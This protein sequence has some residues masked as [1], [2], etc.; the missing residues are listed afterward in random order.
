M[1]LISPTS[2][3]LLD[4]VWISLDLET[5]GLSAD[6]DEI[7]EIGAVKFQSE[8]ALDT[9][10][11]YVN[12]NRRLSSF[13]R[14]YTGITQA[15]VDGS[16]TFPMVMG[17]LASFV[18]SS[19]VVGHNIPFDL[20]F[21]DKK[22][23]RL[24][25]ERS[26]TWD[27]A[28]MLY[29]TLSDYSLV[30]LANW[31]KI[32]HP[33]PHRAIEDAIVTKDVFLKLVEKLAQVD[34][35]TLA[36]MRRLASRSSWVLSYILSRA[37]STD[38]GQA[39][40]SPG[41][42]GVGVGATGLDIDA[43]RTRLRHERAL[44]PNQTASELDVDF[45]GSLLQGGGPLSE[46]LPG[47]EEREEQVAMARAVAE[48]INNG[49]RLIVEAGT[50]VGKSMAYLLPALLYAS[51][52]NKRVVVSTNTINLQEQL[53]TKDIPTLLSGLAG[54]DGVSVEDVAFTQLKGR[55]NYLCLRRWQHLRSSENLSANDARVLAK[56]LV[57]LK[58]TTAG[59]RSEL[60]LG[61]RSTAAPWER[62]SAQGA[63]D[64]QGM[65]GLCFL[66][67]ARDKAAAAHIVV[68]NHAL[69]LSDLAAGGSLIPQ[70]DILIIDEAHHLEEEATRRLGF[71]LA[72][73]LFDEHFQS[74]S[75]ERGLLNQAVDA[76]RGSSTASTRRE[77][78][79]QVSAEATALLPRVRDHVARLY[80][81]L[82][83]ISASDN[84]E[85]Q[86]AFEEFR[87]TSGT[88][89]QPAWSELEIQ[90][91][92]VDVAMAELGNSLRGLQ[93]SLEALEEAGLVDYDGLMLEL[94]NAQQ[95]NTDLRQKLAEFVP[96]PKP[97]GI[98]WVARGGR[99]ADLT[100]HSAPMHVGETLDSLLFSKKQCVV[101]T[102]ATLSINESFD[103]IRQRT[104]FEG[105]EELL[106]G[107]PFDY[108][109]AALLCVPQDM[110][111]PTARDYQSA[112]AEA[113]SGASLAVGG[114]TMALFTS[115]ASLR[116]TASAIRGNLAARG[117]A[118]LAQGVDGSP[119]QLMRRFLRDPKSV[120]LG[121][122]S[123][124][125]GSTS[126]AS[127]SSC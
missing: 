90:W 43:L 53:L 2:S 108:P 25:G 104:G 119:H 60:N 23:L 4:E 28:F 91:E 48:A 62:L 32:P 121:T 10:Q 88:R 27:M 110:P 99:D 8:S 115:H 109:N 103:H 67:A 19:P 63:L 51:E 83:A 101:M 97:E 78:V 26:D 41:A 5:T 61:N 55:A 125:E 123:F 126:R 17:E 47:F 68:V 107:S 77:S 92:N 70:Y 31:L 94:A 112:V 73:S 52:N 6:D 87:V 40:R 36:E 7:I 35:Y 72:Q 81:A 49:D 37:E 100:L 84:G 75:G 116:A 54:V 45:V 96:Q 71:E 79:Q 29:P 120:L 46:A 98:Y 64:C 57:W 56:M 38:R 15:D 117:I 106:L 89:V 24:S 20:G 69:L 65:S 105:G 21:L 13:I 44:R 14:R 11:T 34:V 82:A 85:K 18:G 118:V 124:W 12:P 50:G 122:S 76:F 42:D 22:G 16:P 74:L 102:S 1:T 59:D 80:A 66:R 58:T 33:R 114:R 127:P 95:L 86:Y 111:E 93:I 3:T 113:I 39:V 30:G 9:Y